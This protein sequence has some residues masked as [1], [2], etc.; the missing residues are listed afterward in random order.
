MKLLSDD[1]AHLHSPSREHG[2]WF[3]IILGTIQ[4]AFLVPVLPVH[5]VV[6]LSVAVHFFRSRPGLRRDQLAARLF[7][8]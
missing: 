4:R 1:C 7:R 6:F 8:P 2:K 5:L 3:I